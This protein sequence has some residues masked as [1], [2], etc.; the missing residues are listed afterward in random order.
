MCNLD[1]HFLILL[2]LLESMIRLKGSFIV[3]QLSFEHLHQFPISYSHIKNIYG[4][5]YSIH[6]IH[7]DINRILV[8]IRMNVYVNKLYCRTRSIGRPSSTQLNL[9]IENG[10]LSYNLGAQEK[11][12]I[13]S[14][15]WVVL[16]V[17]TRRLL[18]E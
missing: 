8:Q 7:I 13:N 5:E 4:L 9:A 15:I 6:I 17:T 1:I 3:I 16:Q 12:V 10:N 18:G 2:F 11:V 14:V